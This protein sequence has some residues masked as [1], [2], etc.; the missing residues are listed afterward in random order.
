MPLPLSTPRAGSSTTMARKASPS[1]S[2]PRRGTTTG[3]SSGVV[4]ETGAATGR[5]LTGA[6]VTV[7]VAGSEVVVPSE[8]VKVNVSVPL[9]FGAG[10]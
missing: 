3:V 8:T 7:T 1:K 4:T 10:V 5:S 2:D 6:T 9:L